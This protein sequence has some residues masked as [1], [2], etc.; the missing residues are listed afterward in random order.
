MGNIGWRGR[1]AANAK[2]RR[3][4]KFA[5]MQTFNFCV[6]AQNIENIFAKTRGRRRTKQRQQTII[7]HQHQ[8]LF[9]ILI[10]NIFIFSLIHFF[11]VEI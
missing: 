3:K 1:E 9:R 4:T 7:N 11:F 8:F 10:L 6:C 5:I 2:N